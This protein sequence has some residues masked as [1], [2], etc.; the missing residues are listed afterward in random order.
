MRFQND[1]Y[2]IGKRLE[3]N[4]NEHMSESQRRNNRLRECIGSTGLA[5]NSF[6]FSVTWKNL[7]FLVNPIVKPISQ[8]LL[9]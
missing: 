5:K 7:N 3:I 6:N 2:I 8:G 9:G 1:V 4:S